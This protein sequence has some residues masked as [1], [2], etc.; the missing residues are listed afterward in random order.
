MAC[1]WSEEA[2]CREELSTVVLLYYDGGSLTY[3]SFEIGNLAREKKQ[4]ERGTIQKIR[5]KGH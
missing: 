1:H 4:I 2:L 3:C 5:N